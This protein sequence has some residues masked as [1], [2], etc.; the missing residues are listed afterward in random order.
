MMYYQGK[1]FYLSLD[2]I[3]KLPGSIKLKKNKKQNNNI[4]MMNMILLPKYFCTFTYVLCNKVFLHN[5]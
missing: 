5:V 1:R 3:H 2:E 4:K